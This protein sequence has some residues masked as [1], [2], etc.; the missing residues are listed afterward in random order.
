M[1]WI[2]LAYQRGK[3]Q[4]FVNTVMNLWVVSNGSEVVSWSVSQTVSY[5]EKKF[6]LF[7]IQ[8]F[9]QTVVL[10]QQ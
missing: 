8:Y 10:L 9:S 2:N 3:W 1:D 4:Y 5:N 7:Y 6:N